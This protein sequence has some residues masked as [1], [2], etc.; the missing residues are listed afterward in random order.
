MFDMLERFRLFLRQSGA[1]AFIIALLLLDIL[2]PVIS[3]F[4]WAVS[5]ALTSIYNRAVRD[6]NFL[7]F[8][9]KPWLLWLSFEP[10]VALLVVLGLVVLLSRWLFRDL[11]NAPSSHRSAQ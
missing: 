6:D 9:D 10:A 2:K 3:L 4:N 8:P 1:G 7:K 5:W 11:A